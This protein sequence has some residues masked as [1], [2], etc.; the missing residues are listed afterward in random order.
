MSNALDAVAIHLYSELLEL[1]QEERFG[2]YLFEGAVTHTTIDPLPNIIVASYRNNLNGSVNLGRILALLST[3]PEVVQFVQPTIVPF[4]DSTVGIY[5]YHRRVKHFI[6]CKNDPNV[7][8]VMPLLAWV[9]SIVS[10]PQDSDS[11]LGLD[12]SS[13]SDSSSSSSSQ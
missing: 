8:K 7:R 4:F 13:D 10:P 6:V 9:Q 2:T 3:F 12:S 5:V 11:E 1:L